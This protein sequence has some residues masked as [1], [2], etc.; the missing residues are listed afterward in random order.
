L[1]NT[2][3]R[4]KV[5]FEHVGAVEAFLGCRAAAWAKAAHHGALVVGKSVS[6][7]V[8]LPRKSFDV[9]FT[10]RDGALLRPFILVGKH[11][12]LQVLE[13]T[14]TFGK[15]AKALLAGLV[16]Q[17]VAATALATCAGMLRVEGCD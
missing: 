6:V 1:L 13:D 16:I 9:V 4:S 15:G 10:G 7:L 5:S 14:A 8:V 12:G 3:D 17:I 2:V 11:V